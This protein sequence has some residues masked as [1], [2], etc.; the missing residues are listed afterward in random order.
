MQDRMDEPVINVDVFIIPMCL[1]SISLSLLSLVVQRNVNLCSFS[2]ANPTV[3]IIS[4][5]SA[6]IKAAVIVAMNGDEKHVGVLIED[7]LSA[8]SSVDIVIED[9]YLFE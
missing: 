4:S 6:R 3:I 2:L 9:C 1:E 8:V 7:M 5:F